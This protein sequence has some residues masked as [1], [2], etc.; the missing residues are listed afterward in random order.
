MDGKTGK[1]ESDSSQYKRYLLLSALSISVLELTQ[2]PVHRTQKI[3]SMSLKWMG[4]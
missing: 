1:S 3:L 2:T 4:P